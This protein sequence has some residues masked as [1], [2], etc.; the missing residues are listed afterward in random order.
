MSSRKRRQQGKTPHEPEYVLLASNLDRWGDFI[1]LREIRR[2]SSLEEAQKSADFYSSREDVIAVHLVPAAEYDS[3]YG[4]HEYKGHDPST[5]WL[6]VMTGRSRPWRMSPGGEVVTLAEV[7]RSQIAAEAA[8]DMLNDEARKRALLDPETVI[9]PP[10]SW[11]R[12]PES[13]WWR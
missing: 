5:T 7:T 10:G 2:F 12:V 11:S 9:Y 8:A 6:V 3:R 1:P 13:D 4:M